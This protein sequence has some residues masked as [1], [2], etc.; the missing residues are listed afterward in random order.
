MAV[1]SEKDLVLLL[2][3]NITD[4]KAKMAQGEKVVN[5]FGKNVTKSIKKASKS[6]SFMKAAIAG[7]VTFAA[8]KLVAK[9]F[10][11]SIRVE[12]FQ[13]QFEILLGSVDKAQKRLEQL[14]RFAAKTPFELPE[15]IK[16]SKVLEVLTKGV[17]ATGENLRLIGDA[18]SGTGEDFSR[19]SV[20]VGR[21]FSELQ[22]GGTRLGRPLRRLQELGAIS[23]DARNKIEALTAS[24]ASFSQIWAVVTSELQRFDGQM[25]RANRT[26]SGLFSNLKDNLFNVSDDLGKNTLP[27]MRSELKKIN[28]ILEELQSSGD[29]QAIGR[30]LK[31]AFEVGGQSL[32]FLAAQLN[33]VRKTLAVVGRVSGALITEPSAFLAT[34]LKGKVKAAE[35]LFGLTDKRTIALQEQLD[36]EEKLKG[37]T[38]E[39]QRVILRNFDIAQRNALIQDRIKDSVEGQNKA[40]KQ[41]VGLAST[42]TGFRENEL[43]KLVRL[44]IEGKERQKLQE[45]ALKIAKNMR[46]EL[47]KEKEI[48]RGV[49]EQVADLLKNL[50]REKQGIKARNQ[51]FD[52]GLVSVKE[53]AALEAERRNQEERILQIQE[54]ADK[55][56]GK[57][58]D[59]IKQEIAL[60]KDLRAIEFGI[61]TQRIKQA[62]ELEKIALDLT[63]RQFKEQKKVQREEDRAER[64]REIKRRQ[65][66]KLAKD[67]GV[68]FDE[69]GRLQQR[70][71]APIGLRARR[72]LEVLEK[73]KRDAE[74]AVKAIN[75][76]LKNLEDE[77][78]RQEELQKL[79][80]EANDLLKDIKKNTAQDQFNFIQAGN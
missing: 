56:Q 2:E 6:F 60:K 52:L 43:S 64:R 65:L 12:K 36:L 17:L 23:G 53:L 73:A 32:R 34:G 35:I 14:K 47:F 21:L 70:R 57:V 75:E 27:V 58:P 50:Q 28:D 62:K 41:Q 74:D 46:P 38:L 59:R 24:G 69:E 7:L 63:P 55:L 48:R 8:A 76:R 51:L 20:Q 61:L 54:A 19:F 37:K 5:R 3:A 49:A 68:F 78:L 11:P 44:N 13:A 26:V 25:E 9:I 29:L 72:Q 30:D 71:G 1:K 4:L 33:N 18:A 15:I 31:T 22:R 77:K 66:E 16:A 10:V 40:F 45:Q 67:R 79:S 39:Q 42:I 80:R